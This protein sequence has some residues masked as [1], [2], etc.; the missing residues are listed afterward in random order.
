[1]KNPYPPDALQAVKKL[2]PRVWGQAF[3]P[4]SSAGFPARDPATDKHLSHSVE[5][6]GKSPQL[7]GWKACPTFFHSS[8][9]TGGE[10]IPPQSSK[11]KL[12]SKVRFVFTPV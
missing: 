9:R 12:A 3:E 5:A 2:G 8:L 1:M 11:R 7:A 10:S 4:A 6:T